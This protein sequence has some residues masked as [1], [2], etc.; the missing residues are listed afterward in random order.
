[1]TVPVFQEYEPAADC[2]C[3]GCGLRPGMDGAPSAAPDQRCRRALALVTAAGVVLGGAAAGQVSAAAA[4]P[5]PV[6]APGAPAPGAPAPA[7]PAPG[8]PYSGVSASTVPPPGI[9]PP[10]APAPAPAPPP[11][12]P[13]GTT[14][15][16]I[17][18]RAARWAAAEVPYSM[19][20][21]RP[22]GYRQ[23]CSGYVSMAWN[24]PGNAGTGVLPRY[25]VRIAREELLPG[26]ILLFHDPASPTRGSHVT[27]F[28]GWADAAHTSYVA[29]EQAK[30]YTRKR[31]TPMAYWNNSDRYVAYRYQGLTGPAGMG[32]AA[33]A[34]AS[35]FWFGPGAY[36]AEI[37]RLGELLVARG[38]KRFYAS[39]PGPRWSEADRRATEAFQRAQGWRG[40]AAD[41]YPGPETWRLL[42]TGAGRDIPPP[43]PAAELAS[44]P[45]YPGPGHFR[46]GRSSAYVTL[47]GAQLVKRGHGRFYASGP[48][49]RWS[50]ADR[51]A[52]EA[53]QRA[54]G[55]R[56]RAAD[57]Y[58]GPE[59]WRRLFARTGERVASPPSR[60]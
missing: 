44:V 14:R 11:G 28:G 58:P 60:L 59:T 5:P 50:E 15:A 51:R 8:G 23:D 29:Y 19:R 32:A 18:A 12:V 26:D 2:G 42:R 20:S 24:L 43:A 55:W 56:G 40:R 10:G 17:I 39:G 34:A 48:G 47:L 45:A 31:I 54:Q 57:G 25:A 6:P 53:F 16:E 30:P 35:G 13:R 36:G 9:L 46:P 38:G 33:A 4:G 52:T 27:I 1:M 3:P 37:T 21:F 7:A 49:P 22:D 41:G